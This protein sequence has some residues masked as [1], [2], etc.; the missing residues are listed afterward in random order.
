MSKIGTEFPDEEEIKEHRGWL[1][2]WWMVLMYGG[3]VFG[4]VYVIYY[5]GFLGWSQEGQYKEDVAIHAKLYGGG[6]GGSGL[7]AAKLTEEGI[8][9]YRGNAEAIKKGEN[10]FKGICG[11]CHKPDAT[12]IIGPNLV[13]NIFLHG[14]TDKAIFDLVMDGIPA[15]KIKQKPAMGPMPAHKQ[16]MGAKKVLEIMAWL[17]DKNSQMKAK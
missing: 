1:P 5:H 16:S 13:D 8:N 7:V 6:G 9:P 4:I 17:A 11:A 2:G 14:R 15:D 12:G 10:H 3:F